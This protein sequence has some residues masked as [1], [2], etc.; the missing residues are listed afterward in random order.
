[1]DPRVN[2]LETKI[3][4][5]EL[6][7]EP[8]APHEEPV[9]PDPAPADI[10]V[11]ELW[12]HYRE[13]VPNRPLWHLVEDMQ[14]QAMVYANIIEQLKWGREASQIKARIQ[15]ELKLVPPG[16]LPNPLGSALLTRASRKVKR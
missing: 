11:D 8:V 1:M 16:T 14:Q 9:V 15:Q 5:I 6:D 10:I 13:H 4:R 2:V 3:D 7:E 12:G